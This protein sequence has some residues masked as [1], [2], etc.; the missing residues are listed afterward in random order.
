MAASTPNGDDL[1][2]LLVIKTKKKRA[3]PV[4]TRISIYE[5]RLQRAKKKPPPTYT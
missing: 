1:Q 5:E 3:P 4:R 2:R